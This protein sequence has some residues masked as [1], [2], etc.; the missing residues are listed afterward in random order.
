MVPKRLPNELEPGADYVLIFQLK[1]DFREAFNFID[2]SIFKP[3]QLWNSSEYKWFKT[4]SKDLKLFHKVCEGFPNWFQAGSNETKI[5][6]FKL[7]YLLFFLLFI[8]L[9]MKLSKLS[10]KSHNRKML[11]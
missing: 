4:L 3:F 11:N 2:I 1:E 5:L 6:N 8:S 10:L 9:F 7:K